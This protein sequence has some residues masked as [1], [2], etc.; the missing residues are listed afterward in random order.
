VAPRHRQQ[1][2]ERLRLTALPD[3]HLGSACP[4]HLYGTV[5]RDVVE[6][7]HA[8]PPARGP[9]NL[10]DAMTEEPFAVP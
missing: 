6:Q 2:V 4:R 3:D 1:C 8:R 5:R 9:K 10:I 7:D